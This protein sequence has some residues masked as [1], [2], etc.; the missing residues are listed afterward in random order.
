VD[1]GGVDEAVKDAIAYGKDEA[2]GRRLKSDVAEQNKAL[3]YFLYLLYVWVSQV[4]LTMLLA[5]IYYFCVVNN[6]PKADGRSPSAGQAIQSKDAVCATCDVSCANI[7]WSWFFQGFRAA[8]TF[9]KVEVCDYWASC[10]LMSLCPCFTLWYMNSCT[11][12]NTK[13]GGEQQNCCCAC[14][15]AWFCSCC[16]VA[17][18]A[19][20]LDSIM[21]VETGLCGVT[22]TESPG[23][24]G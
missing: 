4:G 20:A 19:Q 9:D 11:D 23:L 10:V 5:I 1:F 8:H 6:Y 14:I 3:A 15:C 22:A 16:L 24:M 21:E 12:L 2:S 7:F 18:D 13:L 17:Q